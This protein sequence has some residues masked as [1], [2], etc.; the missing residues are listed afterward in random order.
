[1]NDS[2]S[3]PSTVSRHFQDVLAQ[4]LLA[5][6]Q[7]LRP[8]PQQWLARHPELAGRLRAFFDDR[9]WFGREAPG[10]APTPSTAE[11]RTVAENVADVAAEPPL[12]AA[13][14]RFAGYE[15]LSELGKGGMGIV[16]KAR[17]LHPDRL[18]ALKVIRTDR[19][20]EL[21][22]GERR[23][24]ID[25]FHREAQLVAALDQ[26]AHIVNLYEVGDRDSQ[27]YFTMRLVEGGSLAQ[28]LRDVKDQGPDQAAAWRVHE[29]RANARLLAQAARAVHYAHQ[30]GILHRDLK[31][32]N[33]LLD[34]DGQPLVTDFGLARRLDETGS[35]VQSAIE[36]T[37][38]YMAPE[39]AIA[40]KGS[41]TTAADVYSLGAILYELLT[42]KP[43]FKGKNDVETLLLVVKQP[44]VAPR[45]LERRLHRDL[46]TICLKCLEK[47]PA[48]RYPSAAALAD[49]LEN[50]LAGRPINARPAGPLERTWRWCRRNPGMA[51]LTAA[52]VVA[53]V[54][55][56]IGMAVLWQQAEERWEQSEIYRK[57]AEAKTREA[58]GNLRESDEHL[59]LARAA[60]DECFTLASKNPRLQR[61][62]MQPVRWLLLAP[63]LKYYKTFASRRQANKQISDELAWAHFR[64]GMITYAID[65]PAE[66]LTAFGKACAI[67]E[68]LADR[69][70]E[71]GRYRINLGRAC[72]NLGNVQ[73]H[74]GLTKEA[75][76]SYQRALDL[77]NAVKGRADAEVQSEA[78]A[79][80]VYGNIGNLHAKAGR[81]PEARKAYERSRD[82]FAELA[83]QHP[84]EKKLRGKL[85]AAWIN[86]G[87]HQEKP[88]ESVDSYEEAR[89]IL[90]E[91]LC[92]EPQTTKWQWLLAMC[93]G[94]LGKVKTESGDVPGA[95][96]C[97][98]EARELA[99]DVVRHNPEVYDFRT[100]LSIVCLALGKLQTL[101]GRYAD[102]ANSFDRAFSLRE[103]LWRAQPVVAA[104]AVLL[105]EICQELGTARERSGN[106]QEA[107]LLFRRAH[108]LLD[109]KGPAASLSITARLQLVAACTL[110]GAV[111]ERRG[112]L[113]AALHCYQ[114]ARQRL[115]PL[116]KTNPNDPRVLLPLAICCHRLVAMQ[117][118]APRTQAETLRLLQQAGEALDKMDAQADAVLNLR[119]QALC[120]H[121]HG[122]LQ[123]NLG[124]LDAVERSYR[125][126][127][128]IQTRLVA[129]GPAVVTFQQDLAGTYCGLGM[130]QGNIR[131]YDEGEK[132]Y[133]QAL[134]ILQPLADRNPSNTAIRRELVQAC[135]GLGTLVMERG[136][137]KRGLQF[138]TRAVA[139]QEEL[140][141]QHPEVVEFRRDLPGLYSNLAV[142]QLEAGLLKDA[143]TNCRRGLAIAEEFLAHN[144]S[145]IGLQSG[146]GASWDT[147]AGVLDDQGHQDEAVAA[148][149]KAIVHQ[150]KAFDAAPHV[151]QYRQFLSNHHRN[152]AVVLRKQGKPGPAVDELLHRQK[153]WADH[154]GHLYFIA[155]EIT[156]SIPLVGPGKKEL[157]AE[158][159][160]QRQRYGDL[161][162]IALRQA[163]EKGFNRIDLLHSSP[164]LAPLRSR[165][166]FQQ[167]LR[168]L[169]GKLK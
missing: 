3:N 93:C 162:M 35:L 107:A 80:T 19:L 123:F 169:E 121:N 146:V 39:Q 89:H 92:G 59:G 2:D 139:L 53:L 157:N 168:Q 29:Q 158:E 22:D 75:M 133:D 136:Q 112:G 62:G 159:Q 24:W 42:G 90:K 153:L 161:A 37:A 49:D 137:P 102:A 61:D 105:A 43:P 65:Q 30:R 83:A 101:Q 98:V 165:P 12:L 141:K 144:P 44:P 91:L 113:A 132:S 68:Q 130:L 9:A 27:P 145:D 167:L 131:R 72:N 118:R 7:G 73:A 21:S 25:R 40:S 14:S 10:L 129:Q 60:V 86:L 85:A 70:S 78:G 147:L 104:H 69:N 99:E 82:L 33:I 15:I 95:L 152:L 94:E 38:P 55:G 156:A 135:S 166:D 142:A 114:E 50:W 79:A 63:A 71:N 1:M 57:Q 5:E 126:A 128:K 143:K 8:D 140:A 17:Q 64:I 77:A 150:L 13:L 149:R 163:V 87:K 110:L 28:R 76:G 108:D 26:P 116:L 74:T 34:T 148:Y 31:P 58:E 103:K 127:L 6:E 125:R 109:S 111:E 32:A 81:M 96:V 138:S 154:P 100:H 160:A 20:E 51:G 120:W 106:L 151:L 119:E 117:R 41:M 164:D 115:E 97:L 56:F 46:E 36:G 52:L 11:P 134:K 54:G 4:F 18:V 88:K 66:A 155:R 122:A 84:D 124:K 16:Y 23:Q 67:W 48:R 45:N 47:E